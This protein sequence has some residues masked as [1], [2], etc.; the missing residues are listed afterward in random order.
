MISCLKGDTFQKNI[1][2]CI[3][4]KKSGVYVHICLQSHTPFFWFG[5]RLDMKGLTKKALQ[6]SRGN[7]WRVFDLWEEKEE[8][9]FFSNG[10]KLESNESNVSTLLGTNISP[11]KGTFESMLRE[12]LLLKAWLIWSDNH[13]LPPRF[14]P[15]D[16]FWFLDEEIEDCWKAD[17]MA[18][19]RIFFFVG[20]IFSCRLH[21]MFLSRKWNKM[22]RLQFSFEYIS[23]KSELNTFMSTN[24]SLTLATLKLSLL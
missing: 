24:S 7:D 3:Y 17:P 10:K 6:K 2:L 13:R 15:K 11:Y 9:F 23:C 8:A 19:W 21:E 22:E 14:S 18:N 1:I 20:L 12:L 4:V 16:V 5:A